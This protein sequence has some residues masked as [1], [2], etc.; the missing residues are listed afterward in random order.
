MISK[1][2]HVSKIVLVACLVLSCIHLS[3]HAQEQ[4]GNSCGISDIDQIR[5][6]VKSSSTTKDNYRS[7]R[8]ALSR[9]WRLLWHQGYDMS[10]LSKV[11]EFISFYKSDA[12]QA[13]K[14][15][16]AGYAILEKIQA[17]PKRIPEVIGKQGKKGAETDWPMYLSTDGRQTGYSPDPGPSTGEIVWRFPK[18]NH[19]S[20]R[21]VMQDGKI[22]LS[23]PGADVVG[24][25]LDER[26]GKTLWRARQHGFDLYHELGSFWDP[27]VTADRVMIR[28][29]WGGIKSLVVDRESGQ[30][31]QQ[32]QKNVNVAESEK[33]LMLYTVLPRKLCVADAET[34][35]FLW[36]YQ[37][38][39][40]PA[41]EPELVGDKIYAVAQDG[42][43]CRIDRTT[44]KADWKINLSA[45]LRGGLSVQ[46]GRVTIGAADGRLFSLNAADG[47]V[48]WSW[49]CEEKED[50]ALQFFSTSRELKGRMYVGAAGGYLYCLEAATGT[51]LWKVYTGS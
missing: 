5:Q 35:R 19:W 1:Q 3:L 24:Y 15:L 20:A 21:P 14:N 23:A 17:Y 6:D 42:T 48:L 25:C 46:E 44:K 34:G 7:R 51:L 49:Q 2:T 50:R 26:T 29:G 18:H 37:L 8:A 22:Y 27:V 11:A 10:S 43:V 9:W 39:A 40:S 31:L 4:A 38:S 28:T 45:P 30:P 41:G 32:P 36:M 12:P 33:A 47:N 13:P 16:D